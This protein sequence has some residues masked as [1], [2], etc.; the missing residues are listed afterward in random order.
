MSVNI[1]TDESEHFETIAGFLS[2]ESYMVVNLPLARAI[3]LKEAIVYSNMLSK[4]RYYSAHNALTEIDGKEYFYSTA[5]DLEKS[6]TLSRKQQDAALTTL[7][8]IGL[9]SKKV[10]GQPPRRYFHLRMDNYGLQ[11][12]LQTIQS[13]GKINLPKTDKLKC[14]K[15]T[16]EFVQKGQQNKYNKSLNKS[17]KE[18]NS[19]EAGTLPFDLLPDGALKEALLEF[20]KYRS[21]VKNMTMSS[22]AEKKL[23]TSLANVYGDD[24]EAKVEAIDR[25][26]VNNYQGAVFP[27]D[28][29]KY[30]R[31]KQA[32]KPRYNPMNPSG[33]QYTDDEI[34]KLDLLF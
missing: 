12:I 5:E 24:T 3:G 15:R 10:V 30:L 26:I 32:N 6:T 21:D 4:Y 25:A 1:V 28:K 2:Q 19:S 23:I 16:N 13:E 29:E 8:E 14:P 33:S 20:R 9:V 7:C 18:N 34:N 22:M 17:L 31:S 11:T 27:G